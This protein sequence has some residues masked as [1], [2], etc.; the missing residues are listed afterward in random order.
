[1]KCY[2][3]QFEIVEGQPW[4]AGVVESLIVDNTWHDTVRLACHESCNKQHRLL[5]SVSSSDVKKGESLSQKSTENSG[6]PR[7]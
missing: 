5:R 7:L 4:V 6:V 1:M 2:L 3:C